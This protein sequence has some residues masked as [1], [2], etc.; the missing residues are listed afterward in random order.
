[1]ATDLAFARSVLFDRLEEEDRAAAAAVNAELLGKVLD[2]LTAHPEEWNQTSWVRSYPA[3]GTTAC[4]AGTTV[5]MAGH[6]IDWSHG[7]ERERDG[8]VTASVTTDGRSIDQLAQELLGLDD[9][10][11]LYLFHYYLSDIGELWRRAALVTDGRVAVPPEFQ[12]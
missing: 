9:S 11:A 6:D 8:S 3:C 10:A 5:Q 7:F 2:H 4:L 1:M 12:R